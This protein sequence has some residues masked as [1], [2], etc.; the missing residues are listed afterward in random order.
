[1]MK[2]RDIGKLVT[3]YRNNIHFDSFKELEEY[4]KWENSEDGKMVK[5]LILKLKPVLDKL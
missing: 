4:I 1:M 2:L 3:L 5:K